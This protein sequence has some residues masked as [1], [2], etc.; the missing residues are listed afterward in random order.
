MEGCNNI[1]YPTEYLDMQSIIE[2]AKQEIIYR[3]I[4]AYI[5][6]SDG[7][8]FCDQLENTVCTWCEAIN[9]FREYLMA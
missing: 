9:K 8:C 1:K 2:C 5:Y 6:C 7:D 3:A 4:D